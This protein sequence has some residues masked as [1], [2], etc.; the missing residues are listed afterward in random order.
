MFLFPPTPC[1][2]RDEVYG[3][4]LLWIASILSLECLTGCRVGPTYQEPIL[5]VPDTYREAICSQ[6]VSNECLDLTKWWEQWDD[7]YLHF[8][9]QEVDAHALDYQIALE[10]SVQA[11][12]LFW[13]QF[14][15]LLPSFY[16][17][18]LGSHFRTSQSFASAKAAAAQG[19]ALSPVQN[20]FQMGLDA[21][22]E[23]D[24]FGKL[25][26]SAESAYCQWQ[27]T[28]EEIRGVRIALLSQAASLYIQLRSL[29]QRQIVYEK[30]IQIDERLIQLADARFQA[31]LASALEKLPYE[32]TA[33]TDRAALKQLQMTFWQ[34]LYALA[35]LVDE[36]PERIAE[37]FQLEEVY[38]LPSLPSQL[39]VLP[40]FELVRRRPDIRNMERLLAA[41]TEN[42][43]VAVADLFPTVSLTGSSG[44]YASNPL[45][46]ANA[47]FSSDRLSQLVKGPSRIWGYGLFITF[48]VLDFGS[49]AA[50]I[51]AQESVQQ[52]TYLSYQKTVITAL[53]EM[54]QAL[55][56][57]KWETMR[58]ADLTAVSDTLQKNFTLHSSLFEAGLEDELAL[59]L[60]ET[61]WL[62][63][64]EATINSQTSLLLDIIAL[65]KAMGGD[66]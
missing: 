60:A 43:G 38:P 32:E 30:R 62:S 18:A 21:V 6:V 25:R 20:F 63:S 59:R 16:A 29:Q 50:E 48:P 13:V 19:A 46:G 65:Y 33:S 3:K 31:G 49:R 57:R 45:Q 5:P 9:L 7:P 40:P 1:N 27:A 66:W 64:Q 10:Q 22:W 23:L 58:Y 55:A 51:R 56:A 44:S 37:R 41:A 12:A 53:Q 36:L 35:I 39:D 47:G 17:T 24:L 34:N 26:R 2:E 61:E 15:Q 52:Q 11:K 14:T 54:E 28:E 42:V 8:L 4:K